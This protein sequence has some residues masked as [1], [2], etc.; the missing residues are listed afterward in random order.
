MIKTRVPWKIEAL[1]TWSLNSRDSI[2]LLPTEIRA[3]ILE[4]LLVNTK[5]AVTL[6][7]DDCQLLIRGRYIVTGQ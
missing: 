2:S 1:Q 6:G 3:I 4:L 5:E 7:Y